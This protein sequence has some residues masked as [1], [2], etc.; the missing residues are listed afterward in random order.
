MCIGLTLLTGITGYRDEMARLETNADSWPDRQ[1]AAES[2]KKNYLL[3]MGASQ[4]F[5]R[6][7]EVV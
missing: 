3:T 6:L 2:L 5:N 1:R 7:V 4:D